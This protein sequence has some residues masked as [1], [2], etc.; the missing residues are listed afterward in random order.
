MSKKKLLSALGALLIAVAAAVLGVDEQTLRDA[1]A[2][3]G[4]AVATTSAPAEAAGVH[5]VTAAFQARRS[6]AWLTDGGRVIKVL[7]D[8]T[9]GSQHQRFLVQISGGPSILI[10]HNIDLAP[11]VAG[12]RA[13]DQVRFHG[14]Y[15]WTDKGGVVHWT[16]H[17][18]GG[19][20]D[21][22]WIEHRGERYR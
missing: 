7:P 13:G 16:H 21:G 15:E 4:E 10:A 14:E 9:K 22:G 2:G 6:N 12:I 20:R 8:D 19:R 18:P 11:R 5:P 1:L 3:G 17:D